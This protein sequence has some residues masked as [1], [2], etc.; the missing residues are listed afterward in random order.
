MKTGD[1]SRSLPL[2][3][4]RVLRALGRDIR[5]ARLR[6]RIPTAVMAERASIS[7]MTLNK[8]EKGDPGV[9]LGIYATVLFVLG[10]S[11][12]LGDLAD[13]RSDTVGLDLEQ[14]RLPQRIRRS[15]KTKPGP[16][17]KRGAG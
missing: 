7:R 4:R 1:S 8:V 16:S 6:R 13:S 2:P 14:E 9:S 15:R 3:V 11:D 12:R 5:D 17:N 10:L